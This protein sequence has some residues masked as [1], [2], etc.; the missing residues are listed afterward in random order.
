M[1]TDS[2]EESGEPNPLDV[3]T[4]AHSRFQQQLERLDDDDPAGQVDAV[5]RFISEVAAVNPRESLKRQVIEIVADNVDFMTKSA[6]E[7]Q[8]NEELRTTGGPD[9]RPDLRDALDER[10]DRLEKLA[11][12]DTE[13]E[14]R[15]RFVFLGGDSMVVDSETLYSPTGMRRAFN[16][17][18][19]VLPVFDGEIEDWENYLAELQDDCL[20]VKSDAVG[21]RAAALTKLRSKVESSEAYIDRAEAIR[22]GQGILIDVDSFEDAGDAG[23]VWVLYDVINRICD[24]L[25]IT[26]EAFR[27]ELDSRDLR[28][29]SSEQKRFD[30]QRAN[31]WPLDRDGFEPKL[32]EP[33]EG[34]ESEGDEDA[35]ENEESGS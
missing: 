32:I 35:S 6:A 17:M 26:P 8:L 4:E 15:Y 1:S 3:F 11:S 16:G 28:N 20:V 34:Y 13:S 19:D 10:I 29:G 31:F 27:I 30:G 25:E 14:T 33:P 2:E 12:E 7:K 23:T 5:D 9:D 24:D 22:K 21:P 18:F